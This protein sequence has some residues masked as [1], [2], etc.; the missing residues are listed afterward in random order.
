MKEEEMQ[1]FPARPTWKDAFTALLMLDTVISE[2][3]ADEKIV[4]VMDD[5]QEFVSKIYK[6]SLKKRSTELYF[7]PLKPNGNNVPPGSTINNSSFCI[8]GF[9]M[10]SL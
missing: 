4:K 8:Y 7:N 5:I 2:N 9:H 10:I 6:Q 3:D 1:W